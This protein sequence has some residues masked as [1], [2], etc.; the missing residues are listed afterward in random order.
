MLSRKCYTVNMRTACIIGYLLCSLWA[1][2]QGAGYWHTSGAQILDASESSVRIAGIN[3]YGFETADMVAH[4]LYTQDYKTILQTIKNNGYN[5]IRIPFSN[6]MVE[7][8]VVP[9]S[10]QYYNSAGPINTDLQ[11]LDSLQIL[12]AVIAHA[13]QIGLRIIL[14]NHRSEAGNSAE[15]SGLWYT[16]AYPE[17]AWISDWVSLATRYKGNTTVI[18]MDVRNEP[19]N[20][21]SGGSCW[22]CGD[23][24]RDWHVAAA[25]AGNA[26]LAVNPSLLIFVEGTDA[27]GSDTYFWGGQL[28]GVASAPVTLSV[29]HQLVYSPHDYGPKEFQQSWFNGSTYSSLVDVWRAHWG[30]IAQQSIAPVWVGEFGTPNANSDVQDSTPGS[31]GQWF[32]SLVQYLTVNPSINWA[33]WALNGEDSYALLNNVYDATPVN[34]LKQQLLTSI[35]FPLTGSI[36]ITAPTFTLTSTPTV[37]TAALSSNDIGDAETITQAT[38]GH[39]S[40]R[41]DPGAQGKRN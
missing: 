14:D 10:V 32:S 36:P 18:G 29:P 6:Q 34:A 30:Y 26:I 40:K 3:W 28:A 7:S 37:V 1:N 8:P 23:A 17:S 20:A 41:R 13:G 4:G 38:G 33:Y 9:S 35:Q 22:S 15:A 24:A 19:H 21:N 16:E 11:G 31:Q 12:D 2:A 5:T 27:I 25:E 39:N